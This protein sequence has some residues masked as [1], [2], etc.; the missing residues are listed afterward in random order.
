MKKH[1]S[2]G[3]SLFELLLTLAIFVFLFVFAIFAYRHQKDKAIDGKRKSDLHAIKIA[4]EEYEK[5]HNCYPDTLQSCAPGD[6]FKPY[7]DKLPCKYPSNTEGYYYYPDPNNTACR[8]WYW[9]FSDL[10]T[11][12]DSQSVEIGCEFGCGPA[13]YNSYFEYFESSP[14][15]PYPYIATSNIRYV[16]EDNESAYGCIQNTPP[17]TGA[18]CT[19]LGYTPGDGWECDPNYINNPTCSGYCSNPQFYCH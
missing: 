2:K 5:D 1:I 8:K 9:I 18:T 7:I 13:E 16:N 15:A 6:A 17:A 3:L 14:N 12:K 10:E 4:L 19:L 11:E